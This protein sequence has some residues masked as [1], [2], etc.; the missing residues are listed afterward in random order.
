M[1]LLRYGPVGSERP[2]ILDAQ[3]VIRDLS[4]LISD[5]TPE[6]LAP[7]ALHA[8]Q[9]LDVSQLQAVPGQPR[10]GVPWT[11]MPTY[12]GIGLNYHDHAAEAGLPIPREPIMFAKWTSCVCGPNDDTLMP[13]EA[14]QLDWEVELGVVIGKVARN[15]PEHKA[16]EHVAGYC[17][18]NDVSERSFQIGR[19]GGQWSKGKGFDTFGP[20]GP[21]LVTPDEIGDPQGLDLWLKVNGQRMQS[22]NTRDMIFSCAQ[23]VSYCS[24]MMTLR[25]GDLISTGTPSGVGMGMK[26]PRFLQIGDVVELGCPALGSQRQRI[27]GA[28]ENPLPDL[29]H[30]PHGTRGFLQHRQ[31]V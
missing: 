13:I 3:G 1:K 11:G 15:V 22:G 7:D 4:P 19:S 9:A 25:P 12:L 26:P 28:Q 16:L 24:R 18:T 31:G 6:V 17:L 8:L 23:L 27:V 21:Y 5:I 14:T 2:G 29:Q 10:L 20:V 30:G